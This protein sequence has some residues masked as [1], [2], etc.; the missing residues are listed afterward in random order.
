MITELTGE[1]YFMA[2]NSHARINID[3]L[4][5]KS[6]AAALFSLKEDNREEYQDMLPKQ[7]RETAKEELN[8]TEDIQ[9]THQLYRIIEAKFTQNKF[10]AS[11]LYATGEMEIATEDTALNTVLMLVREYIKHLINVEQ[12][13]VD[14][15]EDSVLIDN[16]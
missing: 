14:A 13:E 15:I 10:L 7:A 8:Y 12:L 9:M 16:E 5:F 11:K 4:E 6:A 3:G 2:L 1:F